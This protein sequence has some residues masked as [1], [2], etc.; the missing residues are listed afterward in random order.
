MT[1]P[2]RGFDV[3]SEL[4]FKN[5][6]VSDEDAARQ[7]RAVRGLLEKLANQPGVILADEVGMGKTFVAL[8][9]AL[10]A[11]RTDA[12]KR[13]VVVM[14][15]SALHEKWPRD[16]QVFQELVIKNDAA[17]VRAATAATAVEFLR[18]LDDGIDSRAQIIFLKHGAFH[19]QRIDHW[20]KFAL[21]RRALREIRIGERRKAF[22]RYA[23]SIIR[24]K[25]SYGDP[26]LYERLLNADLAR[27]KNTIN[28]FYRS[29]RELQVKDDPI[30]HAISE[31]FEQRDL[32][33]EELCETL[34]ALPARE[35][36]SIDERL[37][38]VRNAI[39]TTLKEIWPKVLGL[40]RFTSPLLILDE[41]HHLKDP[42]TRLASLFADPEAN[43]DASEHGILAGALSGVFE[44]MLFLTATPF[45]LGHGELLNVLDRFK[46]VDWRVFPKGARARFDA[47][48]NQLSNKLDAA[49]VR[50][51][52]LDERW[53]TLTPED[54]GTDPTDESWWPALLRDAASKP[55][56]VQAVVRAYRLAL[57]AMKEAEVDLKQLVVRH[58]RSRSLPGLDVERRTRRAGSAL[59]LEGGQES[60]GLVVDGDALLPFLLAARVRA[61]VAQSEEATGRAVFAEGLA[62]CYE[63]FLQT[64]AG[65][66]PAIEDDIAPVSFE[67]D[68]RVKSYLAKLAKA[69]PS[70]KDFARHPKI[71]ALISRTLDLWSRGEKVVVFCHFVATGR[72][73]E[74]HL[75]AAMEE[76]LWSVARTKSGLSEAKARKAVEAFGRRF[77]RGEA[78]RN[79]L[80]RSVRQ[81][82]QSLETTL[83]DEESVRILDVVAR[84]VRTPLFVVRYFDFT[85]ASTPELLEAAFKT[86]DAS[87][88]TLESKLVEFLRFIANRCRV[89]ERQRYLDALDHV[90]P[91]VRF[92]RTEDGSDDEETR[93]ALMPNIR[94]VNGDTPDETRQRLML[95]FNTPFFPEILVASSVLAEGVDLHLNC[96]YVIHHDLSWNPSTI[97]QRTG[98]VDRIGAKAE[99]V[100]KPIEIFL[101]YVGETQDEKQ[102]R[103]VMDR[104]RWFQALMGEDYPQDEYSTDQLAN[105][106]SL[107][108]AAARELAF[109]LSIPELDRI[110]RW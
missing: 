20:I 58:L 44:R 16:F 91:G 87:G 57:Q 109:D 15:P 1:W 33:L 21:I 38:R 23:A 29:N 2:I 55:E 35:T 62:S 92:G 63:A 80:E 99:R 77:D 31:V 66:A 81:L 19:V 25:T 70:P 98:R 75:S 56:R 108:E 84:F 78:M 10:A 34:R 67:A 14:V 110:S 7:L 4:D 85:A 86:A 9:V 27:W 105:R 54:C 43:E 49:H 79:H 50:T 53:R 45:Q 104:E 69:L 93:H 88:Q 11:A 26:E 97:E 36:A 71:A 32:P 41:A 76:K 90:Q 65:R 82:I 72:A 51:R 6:R 8:G 74:Q 46:G 96:R 61:I 30:P 102:Y 24:A 48:L 5:S 12:E 22:P 28:Y 83:T 17:D 37:A 64:R 73:I 47:A 107:P 18:L 101:P 52:E 95:S 3:A 94:L 89:D 103:V 39:N 68:A 106:V 59:L 13:P 100:G 40:V 42:A 60:R